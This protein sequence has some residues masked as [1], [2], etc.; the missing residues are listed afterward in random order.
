MDAGGEPTILSTKEPMVLIAQLTLFP[1][2]GETYRLEAPVELI[3]LGK[4][5]IIAAR[6]TVFDCKWG[7]L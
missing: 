5:D 2:K 3:D 7:G 1:P 6:I 4:P